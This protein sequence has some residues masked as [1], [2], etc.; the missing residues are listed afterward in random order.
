M[1]ERRPDRKRAVRFGSFRSLTPISRLWGSDR[2]LPID[3]YYLER[4]LERHAGDVRGHVLEFYDDSYTRLLG[5]ERVTRSDVINVEQGNPNST[6]VADLSTAHDLPQEF[7]DCIIVTQVLQFVYDLHRALANL[8]SALKPAGVILATM[9][10]IIPIHPEEWPFYWSLTAAAAER[11]FSERFP[12]AAIEVES[13]GNVL[14]A[15]A[16]LQGLAAFE[17]TSRELGYNDP[18]YQVLITVRAVRPQESG[19]EEK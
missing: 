16:F 17:L 1:P 10:G 9:P 5:G 11:L 6:I 8:Y 3:R 2:G 18:A 13:H 15:T 12:A 14:A 19:K 7:F 4:F